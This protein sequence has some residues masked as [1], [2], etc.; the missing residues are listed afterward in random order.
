[1]DYYENAL[2]WHKSA[3]FSIEG[4]FYQQSVSQSC[5][6][7]EL[8]LKSVLIVIQ[9]KSELDKSHDTLGIF[10][11]IARKYPTDKDVLSGVRMCRKY[12]TESRY[13]YNG[14]EV[15][16]EEFARQ[17]LEYVENVKDYVDNE[18]NGGC[19]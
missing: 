8:F 7:A 18:C 9:P 3:E 6:A 10:N 2:K 17:F 16:T 1:M 13:P 15:Y 4:G 5:L 14:G 11:V 12:F 19:N